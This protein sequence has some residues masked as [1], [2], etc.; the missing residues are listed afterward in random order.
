MRRPCA[1]LP[2]ARCRRALA[3]QQRAQEILSR[4]GPGLA[5]L[6]AIGLAYVEQFRKEPWQLPPFVRDRVNFDWDVDSRFAPRL[7]DIYEVERGNV[8]RL[9]VQAIEEWEMQ[10]LD[11]DFLTQ[12]CL[13]ALQ[14][15]LHYGHHRGTAETADE[16]IERA[17][18]CLLR[19]I[20]TRP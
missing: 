8:R 14:A 10:R 19:G 12:L 7:R 1:R 15:S 17:L 5:R 4:P 18:A 2:P 3:F 6:R 11:P 13:D 16:C 20:G 9:I